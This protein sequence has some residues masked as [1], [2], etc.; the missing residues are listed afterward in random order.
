MIV[1]GQK[2]SVNFKM[3]VVRGGVTSE[4]GFAELLTRRTIVS[5]H[6]RNNTPSCDRQ[7]DALAG[8]AEAFGRAGYAVL[9]VSRD[10]C[11]SH[12]RYGA[13]KEIGGSVILV[14]DPDD[15]FAKA[16]D[17]VVDKVLYGRRYRG[18][19]RSAFVLG[20]DGTVLAVIEKVDTQRFAEQLRVAVAELDA[21]SRGI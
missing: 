18:P 21:G 2:L 6:M 3:K 5:I 15:L 1:P 9:A 13:K 12:E 14:S 19:A 10:T 17:A 11:G 16:A 20:A 7:V 4:V 8:C